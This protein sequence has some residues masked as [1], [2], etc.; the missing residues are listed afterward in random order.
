[1]FQV[2]GSGKR[3]KGMFLRSVAYAFVF[4]IRTSSEC[5]RNPDTTAIERIFPYAAT[6]ATYPLRIHLRSDHPATKLDIPMPAFAL[7]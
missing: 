2:M 5:S 3:S 4:R 1:M 7:Q 6:P